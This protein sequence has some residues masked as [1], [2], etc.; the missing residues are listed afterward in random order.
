MKMRRKHFEMNKIT[1][2]HDN[3]KDK[4]GDFDVF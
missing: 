1:M 3:S 4:G 2:F